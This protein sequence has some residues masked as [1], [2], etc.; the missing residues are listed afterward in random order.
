MSELPPQDPRTADDQPD[1]AED[2]LAIV[3]EMLEELA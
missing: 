2:R 1:T 3:L